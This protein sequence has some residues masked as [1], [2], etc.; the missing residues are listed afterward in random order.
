MAQ[1][2]DLGQLLASQR[3][4]VTSMFGVVLLLCALSGLFLALRDRPTRGLAAIALAVTVSYRLIF[5][6]GALNH[7]YWN[8]W[9]CYPSPSASA[10][11]LTA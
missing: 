7:H 3:S 8:Y 9:F 2:V 1:H 11:A 6:T 4:H 10:S 5:K